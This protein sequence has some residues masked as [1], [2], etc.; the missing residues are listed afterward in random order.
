VLKRHPG[1]RAQLVHRTIFWKRSH[2]PTV[3]ALA[4]AGL[5]LTT[6]SWRPLLLAGWWFRHR[7]VV[8]P[9]CSGRKRRVLALPGT[10]AVDAAEVITMAE[11]SLRHRSLLL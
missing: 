9:V 11:G 7:L 5:A 2:P 10:F 1:R 3:A 8:D 4:G 6:R